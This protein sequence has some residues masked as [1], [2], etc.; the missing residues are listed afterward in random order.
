M[1]RQVKSSRCSA[2]KVQKS[3][4]F[5]SLRPRALSDQ[6][7]EA[8]EW[9]KFWSLRARG[10]SDQNEIPPIKI[11]WK[12]WQVWNGVKHDVQILVT[13]STPMLIINTFG[14]D[15]NFLQEKY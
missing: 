11:A 2:N 7:I 5:W 15:L 6:F 3:S 10:L 1:M 13:Q 4:K 14:L 12:K 8:W 9:P